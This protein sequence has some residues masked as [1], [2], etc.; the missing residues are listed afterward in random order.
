VQ[1]KIPISR[2]KPTKLK[3]LVIGF[4]RKKEKVLTKK[5]R[6]FIYFREKG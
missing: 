2:N 1:I 3:L 6:N 4:S 5:N